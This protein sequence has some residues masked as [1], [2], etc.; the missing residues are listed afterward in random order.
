MILKRL[1]HGSYVRQIGLVGED[2]QVIERGLADLLRSSLARWGLSPKAA[3]LRHARM[4]LD[5]AEL[6]TGSASTLVTRVLGRMAR[7]GECTE[8]SV[9][10]Q[11]YIA[12]TLP[13]WIRTGKGIGTLISL[14]PAPEGIL[15]HVQRDCSEDIVRRV[16]VRTDEDRE[17]LRMAG[18]SEI[19][20]QQW[21]TP[22]RYLA[23]AARRKASPIRSDAFG[24]SD[25]WELLVSDVENMAQ[26]LSDEAEIRVVVGKPGTYFGS[27]RGDKCEGRWRDD[28]GDG[29]WCAYRRGYG[30]S[31]WHPI[32]LLVDGPV[33]RAMDV[34]DVD[35]WRWAL[36]ARG[37]HQ[38]LPERV[39]TM[40]GR[41]EVTFPAPAQFMTAMEI[42]GPRVDTWSWEFAPDAPDPWKELY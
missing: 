9:G 14:A 3:V 38:G 22:L 39:K 18:V 26:P 27:Y 20:I 33:R 30:L 16:V 24:L 7:L 42:L 37:H 17:V 34:F 15:E 29:I 21:L 1:A 40:E 8:V 36:L 23:C 5:A 35:E 31:H 32:I 28:A 41:V 25:F 12:P 6:P 11:K 13:R 2:G 10:G 19:S 4:H